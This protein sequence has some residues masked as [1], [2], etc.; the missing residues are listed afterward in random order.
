M[1][2]KIKVDKL[3]L[4]RINTLHPT[5]REDVRNQYYKISST[6][7]DDVR[8]RF[9]FTFRSFEEQNFLYNQKPKVTNAKGGQSIHNYG[10]AFDIVMLYDKN[11]DGTFETA[12]FNEDENFKRVTEFFIKNGYEWGGNWKT[13]KDKPH[14]QKTFGYGWKDL[15]ELVDTGKV[16]KEKINGKEYVYP[17]LPKKE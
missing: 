1:T 3:T 12:S 6:L 10:L 15:K 11:N 7:K 9:S 5:I 2:E 17:L 4:D 16:I 13:L 8:L 14:F